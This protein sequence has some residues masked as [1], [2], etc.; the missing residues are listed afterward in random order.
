MIARSFFL[1][2]IV[3]MC[4]SCSYKV[5]KEV[6]IAQVGLP[7]AVDFNIHVKPI[8]SDRCYACHG[9]DK[10]T[11]KAE[12][13]LDLEVEA[14]KKLSGGGHAFVAGNPKNSESVQRILSDDPEIMMPPP[15]SNLVLT[16]R[17]KAIIIKWIEQGAKWKPHWAFIPPIKPNLP[18]TKDFGWKSIN[19]IDLFIQQILKQKGFEPASE[20][21]KERLLRRVTMDLTGLPPTIGEMDAFLNDNSPEAYEKVVDKLLVTDA[22]AERLALDWMDISRYADSHGLH[23]DGWRLMWPWRDWVIE[24]FRQNMPYDQFVGW[25][26]AGDLMPNATKEQKLATAFNRNHPMTAEGGAIDEEFRLNYV[27]D[28]TET[29]GTAIMGLTIGCARCH[30]HKFDPITQ[31]DYYQL[32]AFFNNVK[33]LGMTGDDGNYGPMMIL[34]DERTEKELKRLEKSIDEKELQLRITKQELVDLNTYIDKLPGNIEKIGLLGYYP[35]DKLTKKGDRYLVDNNKSATASKAPEILKGKIGNAMVFTGEYDEIY[36]KDIPN[37]E[38]TDKFSGSLWMKT[39]KR[40]KGKSQTLLGTSGE[41]NNFWSGWDFYLDSLNYLNARLIHSLPHDY[42]QVRS[43]DSIQKNVWN[44]VAFS[45]DGSGKANGLQ[46]FIG[47]KRV[48]TTAPYDHLNKSMKTLQSAIHKIETRPVKVAKSYR[49]FT[50]E[51]GIF[52]GSIDDIRL[53]AKTLTP[54][55]ILRLADDGSF[56]D[57]PKEFLSEYWV[58]RSP[59]VNNIEQDLKDLRN[60]WLQVM[61]PVMEV[62]V[63]EEMPEVRQAYAY[64]RGDYTQPLYTVDANTPEVLPIFSKDYPKNRLGL[65]QWLFAKNNPLTARVAVNRYWQMMFGK[66]LV[67][68]PQDFGV[69]GTLPTHPQLIDWLA[70]FFMENDWNVKALLKKMVMSHTYRQS[71]KATQEVRDKDPGNDYLARSNS[72]RLP[73]EMIRDNALMASGLLVHQLGGE[74]VRPYQPVDL[75]IEKNSFSHKLLHYVESEGDSLYRRGLYTFIRRTSPH[76]AMTVFDTP[77][78]EVCIVRRENTNTPLQALVLMNDTQFVEA[79]RVLAERM[80]KEGG[81]KLEDQIALGFRLAV[82]RFPKE[83]ELSILKAFYE[84]QSKRFAADPK[85]I[86]ELLSVGRKQM[87]RSLSKPRTA[88]LTMVANTILNHD[89]TYM[90]R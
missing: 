62:M 52:K 39:T 56:E 42:L 9:P 47:G 68:T 37:F 54:I 10:N 13:R 85:Q 21:N 49:S 27:W 65:S 87:D 58:Q 88:A 40:E 69:Q 70:T 55:E 84:Q 16:A 25:Q 7:E 36:L 71:S 23:A 90:K 86:S 81:N 4:V 2:V 73:A 48:K 38:W 67:K 64:N 79:S 3:W 41:K 32:T 43:I 83:E 34:P 66:G 63:M 45:Y 78:R 31:K 28:R 60:E 50:G 30:D 76:P 18:L 33:E 75:W 14:F 20:A 8:L 44:H 6:M 77:S 53:Y 80:Q 12:L 57:P 1:I 61:M 17:E 5:P 51:Y 19:E 59:K 35:L 82:S 15:K 72:Y 46:L 29:V 89:E 24:A 26:L 74:S 22:N 11:R